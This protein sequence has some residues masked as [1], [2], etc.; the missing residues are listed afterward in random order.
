MSKR[1]RRHIDPLKCRIQLTKEDWF[2]QYKPHGG[3]IHLDMGCGKGEFIAELAKQNPQTFFIGIEIRDQL[4]V[5][6]H[7]IF[8]AMPNLVFLTGNVNLSLASMFEEIKIQTVYI[9]FPDP[10]SKKKR[11]K[12]RRMI[13]TQSVSELFEFLEQ[14][15]KLFV[16][17]DDLN[18][19]QDM[20][21]LLLEKFHSVSDPE[22]PHKVL[23]ETGVT[24]SWEEECLRKNLA[25]YRGIYR[26]Y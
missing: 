1:I 3:S 26:K 14:N 22:N 13:T 25:I 18:L 17:T 21:F 5:K 24:T 10:Y 6:H 19:F 2:N 8:P 15:G 7:S 20:H 4:A 23:N 12:K 9:N 11:Y 16:Q